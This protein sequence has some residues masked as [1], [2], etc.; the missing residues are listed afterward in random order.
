MGHNKI[1]DT[2]F[3][4]AYNVKVLDVNGVDI[5]S[6]RVSGYNSI[7]GKTDNLIYTFDKP[8]YVD[9]IS[10]RLALIDTTPA[11]P[12]IIS[13]LFFTDTSGATYSRLVSPGQIITNGSFLVFTFDVKQYNIT[14]IKLRFNVFNG[15]YWGI[16]NESTLRVDNVNVSVDETFVNI[17]NTTEDREVILNNSQVI[18]SGSNILANQFFFIHKF[19]NPQLLITYGNITTILSANVPDG[20]N[21]NTDTTFSIGDEGLIFN[22]F[23]YKKNYGWNTTDIEAIRELSKQERIIKLNDTT[24]LDNVYVNNKLYLPTHELSITDTGT[25]Q[26][27]RRTDNSLSTIATTTDL[28]DVVRSGD[29]STLQFTKSQIT[30]YEE[31]DLSTKTTDELSEGTTNK[32]YTDTRVGSYL[33]TNQY[34]LKSDIPTEFNLGTKTTDEL[35]EGT[36]N[37]YYTDTRVGSYLTANQYALKSDIPA[38]FN[39]GTKTTDELSEGTTNKYYTE[40]KVEQYLINNGYTTNSSVDTKLLN[41]E[42]KKYTQT[43]TITIHSLLNNQFQISANTRDWNYSQEIVSSLTYIEGDTLLIFYTTQL[44][45]S[46]NYDDRY[47]EIYTTDNETPAI[48]INNG[49]VSDGSIALQINVASGNDYKIIMKK[50]SDNTQLSIVYLYVELNLNYVNSRF[51]D[52]ALISD[53][54]TEFNLCARI[55]LIGSINMFFQTRADTV[56]MTKNGAMTRIRTIP[57]PHIG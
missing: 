6:S 34:A 25:L 31:F 47:V 9:T 18:P 54:P 24:L 37:K 15:V 32:Y 27:S 22:N 2:N 38:E 51:I 53:V 17:I 50:R 36:T 46:T 13:A 1:D 48:V 16:D 20:W 39:L 7:I 29:V 11:D 26:L 14:E 19:Q 10:W 30:D 28:S 3:T 42:L 21:L 52:Y 35:S 23:G 33:S 43:F 49:V 41:Y 5:S 57:W 8:V 56:G 40:T 55:P 12:S 4:T 44:I 45:N